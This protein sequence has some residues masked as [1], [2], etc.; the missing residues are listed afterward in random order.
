MNCLR[1]IAATTD[2]RISNSNVTS[3]TYGNASAKIFAVRSSGPREAGAPQTPPQ[4]LCRP[5]PGTSARAGQPPLLE[6]VG[7]RLKAGGSEEKG[8]Q[9]RE[10][11]R[12]KGTK[13]VSTGAWDSQKHR[14]TLFR[15]IS[16]I[17]VVV[18]FHSWSCANVCPVYGSMACTLICTCA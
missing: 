9:Q 5:R 17:S 3:G 16:L 2:M 8:R 13:A 1:K 18:S 4:P 14:H 6:S 15:A 11:S 10:D 7:P 12:K